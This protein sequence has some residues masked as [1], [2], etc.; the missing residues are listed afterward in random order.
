MITFAT[1]YLNLI[2]TVKKPLRIS[3]M[4]LTVLFFTSWS[5]LQATS[6]IEEFISKMP[7]KNVQVLEKESFY[8]HIYEVMFEQPIDHKNPEKGS[9]YQRL[10]I[11]HT[12]VDMPVVLV[13]EGYSAGYYYTSEPA[14]MLRANQIIAEHRYFGKSVPDSVQWEYLNTWQSASDHHRIVEQFRKFYTGKWISTGISKGGQTT[15]YHSFYYPDDVDVRIPY[16]APLN[17]S[18]EDRRI[19]SFLDEVGTKDCRRKIRK[20]QRHALRHQEEL[21][22]AF[23]EFSEKKG[24]TYSLVG[25][26]ETAFE[27]CVLE[28]SFAFWQWGYVACSEIPGRRATPEEIIV[29]M[30]RVAGFDYFADEFV[31]EYQPFFYQSYTEMGYYG[32]ELKKFEPYLQHLDQRGFEFALPADAAVSFNDS[33][34]LAL[35]TYIRN[36]AENFIFIYGEYDTWSA[37]AVELNGNTNS[38]IFYKEKGSHRTRIRNMPQEQQDEIFGVLTG[39]LQE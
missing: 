3:G 32:Y 17:K 38:R 9:F 26:V 6:S 34:Q 37:T 29:H 28:Y 13:T 22:P 25:G 11:S 20:F 8:S 30:N 21:L 27:F 18:I 33:I 15:M 1:D 12:G 14:A 36:E 24:Y 35:D 39:F 19:Y 2:Y 16:V 31:I 10:Y 23:R 7:V 5:T 4:I